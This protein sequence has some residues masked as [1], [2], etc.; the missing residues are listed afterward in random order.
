MASASIT[1]RL[2]TM[3]SMEHSNISSCLE[4]SGPYC[5]DGKCPDGVTLAPWKKGKLLVWDATCPDTFAPSY[6]SVSS[7]E[8]Q[9]QLQRK[10]GRELSLH[11]FTPVAIETIEVIGPQSI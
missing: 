1:A 7:G 4:P 8:A 2:G 5:A 10:L 6:T 9:L 11:L 3:Q